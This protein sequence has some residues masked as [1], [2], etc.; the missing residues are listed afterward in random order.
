ML[1]CIR[2]DLLLVTVIANVLINYFKNKGMF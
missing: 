1:K 2:T